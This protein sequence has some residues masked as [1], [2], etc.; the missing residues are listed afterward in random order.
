MMES[1]QMVLGMPNKRSRGR[2]IIDHTHT[3]EFGFQTGVQRVVRKICEYANEASSEMYDQVVPVMLGEE[4]FR[5]SDAFG[6]SIDSDVTKSRSKRLR[7]IRR[8]LDANKWLHQ[9]RW[10]S[11]KQSLPQSG[12]IDFSQGDTLLLPDAYWAL[13]QVWPAVKKARM[14]GACTAVVIYDLI[15]HTHSDIY[16][17]QGAEGFRNYIRTAF[18]HADCF[19]AISQSVRNQ[20]H[21]ELPKIVGES[22]GNF[23]I[24]YFDLGAEFEDASEEVQD[25]V[26]Q[27]FD[28][29]T[30]VRPLLMVGT[31]E[32]RKNHHFV[33]NTMDKLWERYPER[34]LCIVGRPGWKGE[35]VIDRIWNH[36]R[37]Q[38][39]L[40]W[41]DNA[42]DAD[43]LHCYKNASGLI[44]AS[45]AEGFGLPIVE[46]LWHGCNPY[47]SDIDIHREVGKDNCSYF[48]LRSEDSLLQLL[49]VRE[50]CKEPQTNSLQTKHSKLRIR[51][52]SWSKSVEGLLAKVYS[53]TPNA[54]KLVQVLASSH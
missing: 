20:L 5:A 21:T 15:P 17:E 22:I 13:P 33:L 29:S 28:C 25:R 12:R 52:K 41:F 38:K 3:T 23:K 2:L 10:W 6:P 51:P 27:T 30:R 16:G 7:I 11:Q 42:S 53:A 24:D 39:Q 4:G 14:L 9:N 46:A 48:D 44:F 35:S 18:M 32:A 40:F 47:V 34:Q 19:I 31:I 50:Q 8:I 54:Q 26:R 36:P 37:Y 49:E 45:I 1:K 43:L